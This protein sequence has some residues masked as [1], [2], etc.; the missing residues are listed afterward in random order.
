MLLADLPAEVERRVKY[1]GPAETRKYPKG[2]GWGPRSSRARFWCPTSNRHGYGCF[3][4]QEAERLHHLD[5]HT[6]V[7]LQAPDWITFADWW[8]RAALLTRLDGLQRP[9]FYI[10]CLAIGPNSGLVH[11]HL[12]IGGGS[13]ARVLDVLDA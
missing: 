13:K 4:A 2:S 12:V 7:T 9:P 10:G 11:A 5:W 6:V 1:R 3:A 8:A